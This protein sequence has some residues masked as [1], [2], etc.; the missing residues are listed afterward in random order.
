MHDYLS[1]VVADYTTT[2]LTLNPQKT[3]IEDGQKNIIIHEG[4]DNSEERI[5]L[6][7]NSIFNVTLS[8]DVLT[9][10]DA[11]TIYDFYHDST[12][13]NGMAR[14]FQ[15]IHPTD[16]YTYVVRFNSPIPRNFVTG[17]VMGYTNIKLKVLGNA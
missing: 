3:L 5:V 16:G 10:V 15:W 6:S 17:S 1:T 14:T 7:S 12:K 11:G 2:V 13:G 8:W 9:D 4:E